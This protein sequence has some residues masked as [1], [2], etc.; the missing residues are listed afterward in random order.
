MLVEQRLYS[1]RMGEFR[2]SRWS[3]CLLSS[4]LWAT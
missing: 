4:G 1:R 2:G 3:V